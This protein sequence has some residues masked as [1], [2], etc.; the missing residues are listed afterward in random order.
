M[1]RLA[2]I[3]IAVL[4]VFAVGAPV[5]SAQGG[6]IVTGEQ[7]VDSGQTYT[8][9][10][11][12]TGGNLIVRQGGTV[13][14]DIV[15]FGGTLDVAGTVQGNIASLG[16]STRLRE[17]AVIQGDVTTVGGNFDRHPSAQVR[18][19]VVTPGGITS[20]RGIPT[21][22]PLPSQSGPFQPAPRNP[23]VETLGWLGRVLLTT[24]G[25]AMLGVLAMLLLPRQMNNIAAALRGHTAASTGMGA[26]T[27]LVWTLAMIL[28][29]IMTAILIFICIGFLGIPILIALPI[30]LGVAVLLGW[31]ATSLALGQAIFRLFGAA[32]ISPLLSVAMGAIVL[33]GLW[34][35]LQLI[36]CAGPIL[37]WLAT[38]PGLG[39]VV[40][41]WFGSRAY[42]PG[43]PYLPSWQRGG[44]APPPPYGGSGAP[45]GGPGVPPS[46][47]PG[48][49]P[50][51]GMTAPPAAWQGPN[52]AADQAGTAAV[53]GAA[54]TAAAA[55][56]S[57][58]PS[59]DELTQSVSEVEAELARAADE[60]AHLTVEPRPDT[61]PGLTRPG[62]A[63]DMDLGTKGPPSLEAQGFVVPPV[64]ASLAEIPGDVTVESLMADVPSS[65]PGVSAAVGTGIAAGAGAAATAAGDKAAPSTAPTATPIPTVV[66]W[67]EA[68][69]APAAPQWPTQSGTPARTPLD[70]RPPRPTPEVVVP[71]EDVAGEAG[72]PQW[73]TPLPMRGPTPAAAAEKPADEVVVPWA[74]AAGEAGEPQWPT[75]LGAQADAPA[76]SERVNPTAPVTPAPGQW[77]QPWTPDELERILYVGPARARF[78]I[79]RGVHSFERLASMAPEEIEDL[80]SGINPETGEPVM[81]ITLEQARAIQASARML[82]DAKARS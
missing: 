30:V 8:G 81:R 78:L 82:A 61:Q 62:G 60:V 13:R 12:V 39:A 14:G 44:G 38:L 10:L 40:L 4:M 42:Q 52:L 25:V 45:Y 17:T 6:G 34:N 49:P 26:L 27:W 21:L 24:L 9:S 32:G 15:V 23:F 80:F 50:T 1:R 76:A 36:V 48:L 68:A 46:P 54:A 57:R 66:P 35:L 63:A 79:H 28:V 58:I 16:G 73:P 22:P 29:A 7:V 37:A 33:T 51:A 70:P 53:A 71:W 74:A 69:G 65:R 19:N 55:R 2:I 18:G 72:E 31:L 5:A 64:E 11:V 20:P 3:L 47:A 67:Q 43:D 77:P 59:L 75:S 56:S 41:T